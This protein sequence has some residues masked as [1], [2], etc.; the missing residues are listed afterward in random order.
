MLIVLPL[1]HLEIH[2]S[3]DSW[4]LVLD[5]RAVDVAGFFAEKY[6][7]LTRNCS[8]INHIQEASAV[9]ADVLEVVKHHSPPDSLSAR[10]VDV[11]QQDK[12]LLAQVKFN[13]L[14]D[15]VILLKDTEQGPQVPAGG[16]WSGMTHPHRPEPVIRRYLQ[17]RVSEAPNALTACL[18]LRL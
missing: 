14:Q 13:T 3:D 5:G 10:L 8:R 7:A 16:V 1:S 11:T 18:K 17:G 6:T 2:K 9:H 12:W 15:A 4:L